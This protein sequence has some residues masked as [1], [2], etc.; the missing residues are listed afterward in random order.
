MRSFAGRLAVITGA[1]SGIGRALAERLV[2][3][4][5][6]VALCDIADAGLAA[7][8][9]RCRT[10]REDVRV[11]G[12]CCD[13][14]DETQLLAFA[15]EVTLDHETDHVHLLINNAGV[16]GGG[17]FINSPRDE[18]ERVFDICWQGVYQTTRAFL[19]LLMAAPEGHLV[20]LSSAN[21]LR[22]VLGGQIPH[23][24]YSAAKFA[25]RGFSEALIHD[26]R[27][28]APH[29]KVSLVMP[30][31]TA[32]GIVENSA[33]VLGLAPPDPQELA[34]AK[35]LAMT[36]EAAAE[37]ILEGVRHDRWRILIGTDTESLDALVRKDPDA[38]YDADF[39]LRW[40]D[41]N[42]RLQ[43]KTDG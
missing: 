5:S 18:W 19:P 41:A 34:A 29:L 14:T 28:N 24:A 32:T 1:G 9:E 31:H 26:F 13:V 22:A 43:K 27:F 16:S 37:V 38:A 11:S 2:A 4:G 33:D 39:V 3:E 17:S 40:R 20:N 21:A 25:V 23:T 6:H 35:A 12:M 15:R 36:A 42:A 8:L 10:I 30:G 7:T